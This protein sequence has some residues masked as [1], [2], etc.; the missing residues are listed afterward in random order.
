MGRV[1]AG[2]KSRGRPWAILWDY[3]HRTYHLFMQH[4]SIGVYDISRSFFSGLCREW[5][6]TMTASLWRR[7]IAYGV[8]DYLVDEY[9][10]ISK[11][12]YLES[13][14]MFYEVVIQVFA[15]LYLR[16][17]NAANTVRLLSIYE[18]WEFSATLGSIDC[19]QWEWKK[20]FDHE[21]RQLIA[22]SRMIWS[23]VCGIML[24][25]NCPHSIYFND[26]N[27]L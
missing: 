21:T 12:T 17:L 18:S 14:Y 15:E 3:F 13:I 4:V 6:A 10:R 27:K 24:E 26:C 23:K 25:T 11:S 2:E 16:Q 5:G 8:S 7:L 20:Y 1:P 22:D 9:I 19:M